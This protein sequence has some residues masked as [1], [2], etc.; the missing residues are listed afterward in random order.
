MKTSTALA[1]AVAICQGCSTDTLYL[2]NR[3]A[4]YESLNLGC[5]LMDT[6]HAL[7][8]GDIK[9]ARQ[10][11][12]ARVNGNLIAFS[13]LASNARLTPEERKQQI[14]YA[15]DIS[16]YMVKHKEELNESFGADHG[17]RELRHILTEPADIRELDGLSSYLSDRKSDK[18]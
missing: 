2:N 6:L 10:V 7:D 18:Q 4:Y 13:L 3:Q 5:K 9:S 8:T 16:S 11:A 14:A 12:L 15:R 17:I 1:F